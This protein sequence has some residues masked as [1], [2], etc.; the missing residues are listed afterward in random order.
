VF[1]LER[2]LAQGCAEFFQNILDELNV[3]G[4]PVQGREMTP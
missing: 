4:L 1:L 2:G 3:L